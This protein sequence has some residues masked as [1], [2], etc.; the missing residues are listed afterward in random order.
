[1]KINLFH[2]KELKQEIQ[3]LKAKL[4]LQEERAATYYD[5][6]HHII[7]ASP[8]GVI[9]YSLD[10]ND[11]LIFKSHNESASKILNINLN[12]YTGKSIEE[13]FPGLKETNIPEAYKNVIKTGEPFFNSQIDYEQN[14]IKGAYEVFA[15][16]IAQ[17]QLAV[18][19]F[20]VTDNKIAERKL[21]LS[22]NRFRT[23]FENAPVFIDAFDKNG[24]CILWN[25]AC[26]YGFGWTMD[27]LNNSDHP[28]SLLYQ[29]KKVYQEVKDTMFN[30]TSTGFNYY[31]PNTKFGLKIP[32]R[33]ASYKD[34]E[35]NVINIGY[36]ISGETKYN[37][38]RKLNELRL[39]T[40]VE[41]GNMTNNSFEDIHD[42]TLKKAIE[43]TNSNIGFL[44]FVNDEETE[45]QIFKWSKT[46]MNN[47]NMEEINMSFNTVEA[48]IWADV[49]RSKKPTIINDYSKNLENKKGIPSGHVDI[50]NYLSVPA[51]KNQKITAIASVANKNEDY[52]QAD[53][54]QLSLLL[55]GMVTFLDQR[56]KKKELIEAK[57]KAEESNHLKSVF[58]T[59]LSHEI[60]T[61]MNGI[62]GLTDMLQEPDL[63]LEEQKEF[64]KLIK[65]GSERLLNTVNDIVEASKIES[66]EIIVNQ[67]TINIIDLA[68]HIIYQHKPKCEEKGLNLSFETYG[69][70]ERFIIESDEQKIS[71]IINNILLNA[72]KFTKYGS[73]DLEL[74]LES[75]SLLIIC[76]DSGIGIPNNRKKAIFNKFEQA[77]LKDSRNYEGSGLGLFIV[78]SYVEMLNGS[79]WFDSE[80]DQ[81][82]KFFV[83]IPLP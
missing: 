62:A 53:V 80:V 68:S 11:Q 3:E 16:K 43:L 28:L 72:I 81:G 82:S 58:L 61:P 57:R 15:Y 40:L 70:Y 30:T 18:K 60:R 22:E 56:N 12:D 29:D 10:E 32:S 19:F 8:L 46:V 9:L 1:M 49:I 65:N 26:E 83:S 52:M 47:C 78:K 31:N 69:K 45:A 54:H 76:T 24:K 5:M 6:Y 13:A 21:A 23:I 17:N 33:W 14:E 20:D 44:A 75:E 34:T 39:E 36:D 41:L 59:N 64:I 35:G 73:I 48:G 55:D 7:E 37:Q 50:K 51:F 42:F 4:K 27:E 79:I 71:S 66:G 63:P 67:R 38:E 25:K 77:E 74:K 2:H